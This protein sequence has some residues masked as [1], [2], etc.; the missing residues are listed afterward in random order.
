MPGAGG[1]AGPAKEKRREPVYAPVGPQTPVA[2]VRIAGNDAV[3][4]DKIRSYLQTRVRRAYD[5]E[6]VQKDVRALMATRLFRDVRTNKDET[7]DGIIVTYDVV[8]LPTVHYIRF[9]GNDVSEKK[10]LKQAGIGVGAALNPYA[11]E[12]ARRKLEQYYHDKGYTDAKVEVREGDRAGDRGIVFAI[13]EGNRVRV[14]NTKIEGNT[15]L[16]D[17]VLETRA[18]LKTKHGF[19]WLV[20]GQLKQDE[21]EQDVERLTAFYR[22]FGY[23]QAVVRGEIEPNSSGKWVTAVFHVDE[24]PR[25]AVHD[26]QIDGN[27]IFDEDA[28]RDLLQLNPG[29]P[30]VLDE[31]QRD[32]AR[33]RDHYGSQGY[34]FADI[35]AEPAFLLGDTP[36][37]DIVYRIEEGQVAYINEV[38]VNIRGSHP[39]TKK[40]VVRNYAALVPYKRVDIREIRAA[41]R[42]IQG[43]ALFLN[44]PARGIRPE[45][46]LEPV[47]S[48][49]DGIQPVNFDEEPERSA[50]E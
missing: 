24:G 20:N 15:F 22:R 21:L 43:S 3:S 35:K 19:L 11:V 6:L 23:Y 30:F 9:D 5:P 7:P 14:W 42:R 39:H 25:F 32:L 41:E 12:E 29:E 4:T 2:E 36:E 31:M 34:V 44:D 50:Y 10:L 17:D 16:S 1:P 38:R 45:V 33:L 27:Q 28:L 48:G 46:I 37:L 18:G 47:T 40:S 26:I 8:E 13:T 49:W